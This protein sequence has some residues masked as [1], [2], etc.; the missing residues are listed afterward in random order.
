MNNK[1]L[2]LR[3]DVGKVSFGEKTEYKSGFSG[4]IQKNEKK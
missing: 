3:T 1:I 2:L 4:G